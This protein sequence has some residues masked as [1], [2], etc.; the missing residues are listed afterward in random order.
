VDVYN[1]L[2]TSGGVV[3]SA[4]AVLTVALGGHCNQVATTFSLTA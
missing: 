4:G 1:A 3:L 2:M